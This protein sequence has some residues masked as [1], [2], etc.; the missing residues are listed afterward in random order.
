MTKRRT[1]GTYV[2]DTPS[3][4]ARRERLK[5]VTERIDALLAEARQMNINTETLIELL[6]ERDELMKTYT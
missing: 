3:P 1:A 4:L 2:S 5:I 6:Q